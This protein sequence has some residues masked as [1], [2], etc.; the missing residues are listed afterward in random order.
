MIIRDEILK[1][2]TCPTELEANLSALLEALNKIRLQWA[3]PM[4]VSSGYRTAEHNAEIHGASQ[5]AHLSCQAADIWDKDR[6][7]AKWCVQ[8]E[9]LLEI[10]G[11][12]M[13]HPLWTPTWVHLQTRP[14]LHRFFIP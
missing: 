8:N 14:A 9:S 10:V 11:L 13:E 2:Q 6:S 4:I 1:G 3:N 12:W 5:S 7:F